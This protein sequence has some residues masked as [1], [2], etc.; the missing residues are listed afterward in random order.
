MKNG[1]N[2]FDSL[3]KLFKNSPTIPINKK[4]RVLII[5]DFHMGDGGSTDDF[6]P[7]SDLLIYALREFYLPKNYTL[8]LNG[9]VEELQ[10]FDYKKINKRWKEVYKLFDEFNAKGLLYKT[11]GNHDIGLLSKESPTTNYELH[12]GIVLN[13]KE[14]DIFIFHG[15]QA[16]AKYNK[17]NALVGYTLRYLAN[18]LGIKNYSVAHNSRKKF[19]IEKSTYN[20]ASKQKVVAIIGH[21]HRPLF[22]SLPK[23]ERLRYKIEE[24][25]RNYSEVSKEES[26]AVKK[27]IDIYK[28]EL[29]KLYKEDK[30]EGEQDIYNSFIHLP[31]LFN[32][33]C[34]I[35]KRGITALEISKGE[36]SL[37]HWFDKKTSKKYLKHN[38]Y[39]PIQIGTSDYFK[40]LINKEKLSYI[41]TR[42]NLL[43]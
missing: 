33:G 20:F 28:K 11:I 23:S 2:N 43:T 24:L 1:K 41:F 27:L 16:S 39:D 10:R 38:G 35:G 6:I 15:H 18:P 34:V 29:K 14:N 25:C 17:H 26:K 3:K 31:C 21:T 9:D 12:E 36:I 7:N 37:V 22:E 19:K 4:D 8:I 5:S 13:Y 32:S 40:M 42:I 30:T